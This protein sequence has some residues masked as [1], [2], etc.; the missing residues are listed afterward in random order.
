MHPDQREHTKFTTHLRLDKSINTLLGL[1]Q[2]IAI[3]R[4]INSS[5]VGLLNLWLGE[6][7]E[8]RG[9]PPAM[10]LCR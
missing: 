8:L 9:K 10:S 6:H 4:E 7:R 1:I 3:D 5:E 2:G